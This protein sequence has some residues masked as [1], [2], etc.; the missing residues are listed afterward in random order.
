MKRLNINVEKIT[1]NLEVFTRQLMTTKVLGRYRSVFRSRGLEFE[2]Y[3]DYNQQ[4]DA[5][6]IDW[7]ASMR[8][9]RLMV[10]EYKEKRNLK[11]FFIF[12]TS[13]S[14]LFGSTSKLK[15]EYAAELAA[16]FAYLIQ[17]AGD[18]FGYAL[19][20][21]KISKFRLPLKGMQQF[22]IFLNDLSDLSDWGGGFKLKDTLDYVFNLLEDT[23]IVIIIS[24][25]IGLEKDKGWKEKFKLFTKKFDTIM[26]MVRD[27]R[28]ETLPKEKIEI[29]L[30]DPYSDNSIC[31]NSELIRKRYQE[32]VS[33][34]EK[35][36]KKIFTEA[37]ADFVKLRTD[38]FFLPLLINLL[39]KRSQG[40]FLK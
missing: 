24:D 27:V 12:D 19:F 39:K 40:K 34:K 6:T 11:I 14:M 29:T 13:Q 38:Q 18:N 37:G 2:D 5:S 3:R 35:E 9:N 15:S 26:M 4:D 28:D 8:I 33:K 7:K 31:V 23:A 21:N 20:N 36:L 25:F 32:Y 1:K 10:R 17:R 30:Q 22:Y 16:S